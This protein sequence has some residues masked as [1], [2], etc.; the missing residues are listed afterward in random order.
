MKFPFFLQTTLLPEGQTLDCFFTWNLLLSVFSL[1]SEH[2]TAA[3]EAGHHEWLAH[4]EMA[5]KSEALAVA[6]APPFGTRGP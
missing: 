2:R 5:G 1:G 6:P 4:Q 3:R